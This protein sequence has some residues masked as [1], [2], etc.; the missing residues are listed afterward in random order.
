ME[1]TLDQLK[2]L[3]A[4]AAREAVKATNPP[5]PAQVPG[6]SAKAVDAPNFNRNR[7]QRLSL[8]RMIHGALSYKSGW[9]PG[10][11][12][13]RDLSQATRELYL[14]GSDGASP[15]SVCVP[16]T[17]LA[18]FDVIDQA[19]SKTWTSAQTKE[20]ATKA[21]SESIGG[22][23]SVSYGNTVGSTLVPPQFLQNEFMDALTSAVALRNVPGVRTLPVNS[24]VVLLPRENTVA[25]ASSAAEAAALSSSDPAFTQQSFTIQKQYGYRT[26]SNELLRDSNPGI[27][28]YIARTLVRDIGL[29]QDVQYLEGSGSGTNLTGI[30]SYS[31]LTTSS[32]TAATNGSAPAGDDLIKMIYDIRK[33]NTEPNAWIMHPRT[34]QNI[35]LLKDG[36]GRYL[37]SDQTVW[38]APDANPGPGSN[39]TG[40]SAAVGRL[41]G[42]PVFLSTQ[43]S[44]TGTQGSSSAASY[45]ILGN[46]AYSAI[47]ERQGIEIAT[48]DQVAFNSDQTAVRG[49]AR[50]ALALTQPKAFSVSTG[51]I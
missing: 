21:L 15:E 18:L 41:L 3:T 35:Q 9:Q 24:N 12:L 39:F 6:Q 11:E 46:F 10:Y 29:F 8:G 33:A 28:A 37:F 30:K 47:L 43:I 4:D 44:I 50:S 45:I 38:G 32:F 48:S 26:Y 27:D 25:A 1:I 2:E 51:I 42:Y 7:P 22:V 23:N 16:T 31:G 20:W 40:P 36:I 17:P 34:L 49:I 13:E 5:D 14:S 19:I